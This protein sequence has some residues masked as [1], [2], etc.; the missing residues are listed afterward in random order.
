MSV[1]TKETDGE[2]EWS[3]TMQTWMEMRCLCGAMMSVIDQGCQLQSLNCNV[4]K[5]VEREMQVRFNTPPK[6][7]DHLL[8]GTFL[9]NLLFTACYQRLF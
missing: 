6:L 4:K 5:L 7:S 8:C 2:D 3:K 9:S 1:K